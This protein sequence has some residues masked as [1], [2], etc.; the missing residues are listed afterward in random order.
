[1]AGRISLDDLKHK[2]MPNKK[3]ILGVDVFYGEKSD[4]SESNKADKEK[5]AELEEGEESEVQEKPAHSVKV[6][7]QRDVSKIDRKAIMER[8]MS[9]NAFSIVKPRVPA[10][11][12]A[13]VEEPDEEPLPKK[14]GK[15]VLEEEAEGEKDK[16]EEE[17]PKEKVVAIKKPKHKAE[18]DRAEGD[19]AEQGD[20]TKGDKIVKIKKPLDQGPS[21]KVDINTAKINGMA[22]IDRI[23]KTGAVVTRA[24][25]FYMNN[26]KAFI[27]K[28]GPLFA[29]YK[30]E[31][32]EKASCDRGPT[33]DFKLMNHQ[34]VVREYLNVYSPYRGLLLY[35]GLGSGK[36]CSSIAI[37][38]GLKSHNHI[39][40]MTLASLKMN[41]FTEMKSCGDELYKRKQFW[42]FVSTDGKPDDVAIL[43]KALSLP[44]EYIRKRKG[45][46]LQN[47]TKE[48]NF[49]ELADSDQKA[50]DEQ[51]DAMIRSKY[52]DINYNGLNRAK[53]DALTHGNSRNPFDNSTVIID[54]AHNFVSRIVNKMGDKK[55]ISYRL[56]EY[57][58][59]ATNARIVLLSGTPIINYPNEIGILFN[60]L[61][62]YIKTW[63]FPVKLTGE[64]KEKPSR[65]NIVN[66]FEREGF[67]TYD[68]VE[69]SGDKVTITRNPFGFI[70]VVGRPAEKG[71]KKGGTKSDVK[72]KNKISLKI[73][74]ASSKKNNTKKTDIN[75]PFTVNHHLVD[76][77][78][79]DAELED[80]TSE[81]SELRREHMGPNGDDFKLRGGASSET[82]NNAVLLGGGAFEEYRGVKFDAT[83]NISD[84]DFVKHV[85]QILGK[86]GLEVS[87]KAVKLIN[88][89]ALP[90]D[91]KAFLSLFVELD[92][93][94]MKNQ[95]VFQRR[96]LGLTSY[97][98]NANPEL[99]PE[100]VPS[101]NDD[102]YHFERVE[103]SDYQFGLYEE[104]RSIESKK[105]K[106]NKKNKA[107]QEKQG[108]ESLFKIASTYRIASR[109]CCN[110]AFPETI[111]R[112]KNSK[113]EYGVGEEDI[114]EPEDEG[115]AKKKKLGKKG[116]SKKDEVEPGEELEEA[117]IK[118]DESEAPVV[119]KTIKI[120]RPKANQTKKAPEPEVLEPE[121]DKESNAV[122]EAEEEA[123]EEEEDEAEEEEEVEKESD[124]EEEEEAKEEDEVEKEESDED[125]EE[126]EE[127]G[128]EEDE[129]PEISQKDDTT[130][131][132]RVNNAL[133]ALK[134]DQSK[135]LSPE[136]LRTYSPKFLR[137]LKN[138][139]DK[140]HQG[141]HLVY[142]QFRT[143]EGIGI[144][145]VVLE[146]NGFAEFKIAKTGDSW[147]IVDQ[148]D[149]EGKPR[150]ALYTGTETAEE[151][152]II[153]NIYNSAWS[154]V[155]ASI[156]SK[157]KDQGIENNFMGEAIKI[158]MITSSGAE[159]INLKNTR[160]VHIVEPYWHMVRLNQVIG[161]ARRLCSHQ[162]LPEELR[163]V[164]VFLYLAV[165]S[166]AQAKDEKHIEL[167]LRDISKLT[168]KSATGGS[169]VSLYDRYLK[170]LDPT[171]AVVTTDQ[172][173]LE[174][175]LVKDRVNSQ[176]LHAVK[177]TAMDC[178]L[179]K[180]GNA[181]ENMVCY[182][183]GKV[184]SNAFGSNPDLDKDIAA[185]DVVE[186]AAKTLKLSEI[187]VQGK[188]YA[189]DKVT[190]ELYDYD[191]YESGEVGA[192][193][194][195]LVK[196]GA[197]FKIELF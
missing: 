147:D 173:L 25:P 82:N 127:S 145:K 79:L 195:K 146:A 69:Y 144:L 10:Q 31:D 176:I 51:I 160:Y 157:I 83:G 65:E 81:T 32:A 117:E 120:K 170:M 191:D 105:E 76:V 94:E 193:I 158:F 92:S 121:V 124:E 179:Y 43:S 55:S 110:F 85:T 189:F 135:Y 169:T 103:M 36:T 125:E 50:V 53:L 47:I 66:W 141:L 68:Y 1:M 48:P 59:S 80:E 187:T 37:A 11:M 72:K 165:L 29:D 30:P 184:K 23:P 178:A 107:K 74:P 98:R 56:Y 148:P 177:E 84:E 122:V 132:A 164:Q 67:N 155:P 40:V 149:S 137:I 190:K 166:E 6:V 61:R 22:V 9:K 185:K 186:V 26:R 8:L 44:I 3:Q 93:N 45:A 73:K 99:L 97:F 172:M 139:Q 196:E 119:L 109:T 12:S 194:G 75:K 4:K 118:V 57:L 181:E 62:G 128:D 49:D 78:P 168:K 95:S 130:F 100:F 5:K 42:E 116:G 138:I 16:E 70:N 152:E 71:K 52:T 159:G 89:K 54:E 111:E 27:E 64:G 183:F 17:E 91:S 60:I 163:T 90:D 161:R 175:A 46:W 133:K 197:G 134:K 38:E 58:M 33:T 162:D 101:K 63:M 87:E 182:T 153:R 142:S 14:L 88:H 156:V 154:T 150:F 112:P 102:V 106:Q 180:K 140:D 174:N 131:A 41:F 20:K 15:I 171:P 18:G 19:R 126:D 114:G 96:I 2:P 115:E 24:S 113:G 35:H 143:L 167:R 28:L 192:P 86:R 104:I 129:A 136:G 7:D 188:K 77:N 34:R 151:K 21:D 123:K 108:V 13:I 39:Y